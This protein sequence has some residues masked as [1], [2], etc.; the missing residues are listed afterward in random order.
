MPH[1]TEA[2]LA[3]DEMLDNVCTNSIP[4]Q[5]WQAFPHARVDDDR[6]CFSYCC[7]RGCIEH[8]SC[9]VAAKECGVDNDASAVSTKLDGSDV[10]ALFTAETTKS[11]KP[12]G[13]GS[14]M[15]ITINWFIY[16]LS[17][18]SIKCSH[19]KIIVIF[20]NTCANCKKTY[21]QWLCH[22]PSEHI[23]QSSSYSIQK[24][25]SKSQLWSRYLLCW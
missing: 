10:G 1:H 11:T 8:Q 19:C 22:K 18:K 16:L 12:G 23:D 15:W 3:L 25:P 4:S 20:V 9:V 13:N 5:T 14:A 2:N 6:G 17:M 7:H 21:D 24:H